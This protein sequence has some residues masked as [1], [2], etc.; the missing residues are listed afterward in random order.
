MVSQRQDSPHFQLQFSL[1][2][3][4]GFSI[5]FSKAARGEM[6]SKYAIQANR[7][8]RQSDLMLRFIVLQL[9]PLLKLLTRALDLINIVSRA[10]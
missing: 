8:L 10:V 6:P 5:S 9:D 7:A 2:N 4:V 1:K 3:L